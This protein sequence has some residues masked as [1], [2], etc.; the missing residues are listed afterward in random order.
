MPRDLTSGVLAELA[1]GTMR[2]AVFVE[3]EFSTGFT[4]LWSGLGNITALGETWTGAGDLLAVRPAEENVAVQANG[5]SIT[6]TGINPAFLA[7]ALANANQ[8]KLAK[9][10][11]G[12]LTVAG[13]VIVD[14]YLFFSGRVDVPEIDEGAETATLTIRAESRLISLRRARPRRY[15][16]EDQREDFAGDLGFDFVTA[17]QNWS[18][19]WGK[20]SA[21]NSQFLKFWHLRPKPPA[22][23]NEIGQH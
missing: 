9:C 13:A 16:A 15:T 14:P 2:P 23:D 6:L 22:D 12:F 20:P 19:Q 18:G 10:Y 21:G 7:L 5:M 17:I 11:I 8:S 3:V 1:A 4:R